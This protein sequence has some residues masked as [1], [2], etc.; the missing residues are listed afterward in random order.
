MEYLAFEQP[1]KELEEHMQKCQTIGNESDV[2]MTDA[3]KKIEKKTQ[4][5]KK[6]DL[7]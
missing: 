7:R 4:P 2:D 1:I 6:R 5:S 3:C